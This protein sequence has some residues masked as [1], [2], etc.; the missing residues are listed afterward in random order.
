MWCNFQNNS[1]HHRPINEEPEAKYYKRW[2]NILDLR[3]PSR[4][5]GRGSKRMSRPGNEQFRV[6]TCQNSDWTLTIDEALLGSVIAINKYL[7]C[8]AG[9]SS[10]AR[11]PA[12]GAIA[13]NDVW[14]IVALGTCTATTR[15]ISEK[16]KVTIQVSIKIRNICYLRS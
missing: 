3:L 12:F 6:Q 11:Q 9:G 5:W 7:S 10:F 4:A 15:K 8:A 16:L 2:C 14:K 1:N 13:G